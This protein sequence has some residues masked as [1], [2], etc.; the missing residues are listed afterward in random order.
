MILLVST[1][2]GLGHGSGGIQSHGAHHDVIEGT[3]HQVVGVEGTGQRSGQVTRFAELES[4]IRHTACQGT[5]DVD[6]H[7]TV[8]T[9]V[10]MIDKSHRVPVVLDSA[11]ERNGV[12]ADAAGV[13]TVTELAVPG[14]H[15]QA[16]GRIADGQRSTLG[17]DAGVSTGRRGLYVKQH[18][19][20]TGLE[21]AHV[22]DG[23][24]VGTRVVPLDV[25]GKDGVHAGNQL[26]HRTGGVA[27][28]AVLFQRT[29]EAFRQSGLGRRRVGVRGR[30]TGT[31]HP[32]PGHGRR[33]GAGGGQGVGNGLG[34]L[35]GKGIAV[36]GGL[37]ICQRR[38]GAGIQ[39]PA[40]HRNRCLHG[41]VLVVPPVMM[42]GGNGVNT[43]FQGKAVDDFSV[44]AGTIYAGDI[45]VVRGAVPFGGNAVV[46]QT[47]GVFIRGKTVKGIIQERIPHQC[48]D[49]IVRFGGSH[50]GNRFVA[51]VG[52]HRIHKINQV[53]GHHF[54]SVGGA[55]RSLGGHGFISGAEGSF[56]HAVG[57]GDP[58]R[59]LANIGGDMGV[60]FCQNSRLFR[61]GFLGG[62]RGG[63]LRRF[64]GS[65]SGL[66][67]FRHHRVPCAV[68]LFRFRRRCRSALPFFRG[69][70]FP[71]GQRG[72]GRLIRLRRC[73]G[74]FRL[75]FRHTLH[76]RRLRRRSRFRFVSQSADGNQTGYH[77]DSQQRR[78]DP[79]TGW[80]GFSHLVAY[81]FLVLSF[82][83]FLTFN[84]N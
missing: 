35:D 31:F 50:A 40:I 59:D 16:V 60:G 79:F 21:G 42:S 29:A 66:L 70:F 37:I 4:Y 54:H 7:R 18:S 71:F 47:P 51:A 82:A 30:I 34:R 11:G 53:F 78:Q 67:P 5:V 2:S 80:F 25:V 64:G 61:L 69:C 44:I 41:T 33:I 1:V 23:R 48:L 83:Q 39:S 76:D 46:H 14:Q 56:G 26:G 43:G 19:K 52:S 81:S 62:G 10:F 49:G 75:G 73:F 84:Q 63:F 9:I 57:P 45:L 58:L 55:V 77:T 36:A 65:R 12:F 28:T 27:Q 20:R 68:G 3:F 17:C 6:F 74:G 22:V 15:M 72:R 38:N 24:V 32:H 8:G 13:R